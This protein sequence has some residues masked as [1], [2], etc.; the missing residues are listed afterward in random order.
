LNREKLQPE[1]LL[2]SQRSQHEK[3]S[4]NKRSERSLL[5]VLVS[6]ILIRVTSFLFGHNLQAKELFMLSLLCLALILAYNIRPALDLHF[7]RS[8]WKET[9]PK[10]E[11]FVYA[12]KL[13]FGLLFTFLILFI[14]A[15]VIAL[16]H[17]DSGN[18]FRKELILAIS[19]MSPL[20]ATVI[21]P[22]LV[23]AFRLM[24]EGWRT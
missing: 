10:E 8:R 5:F 7:L 1:R 12:F 6:Y 4:Y 16:A 15:A 17:I 14:G 21:I 2:F 13:F 11:M 3:N 9:K 24:V 23:G 18:Q 22:R 19:Y 20:V